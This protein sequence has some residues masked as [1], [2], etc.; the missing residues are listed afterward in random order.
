MEIDPAV[1]AEH[2]Y[3]HSGY[4]SEL[5]AARDL[6]S[7]RNQ[8]D[9]DF[10]P[11]QIS[12]EYR[13]A[14]LLLKALKTSGAPDF[15]LKCEDT[16]YGLQKVIYNNVCMLDLAATGGS[17]SRFR[18]VHEMTEKRA[19]RIYR[20]FLRGANS[21]SYREA[22]RQILEDEKGHLHNYHTDDVVMGHF[23][24][25]DKWAFCDYL[26]RKYGINLLDPS[27]RFWQAYYRQN[28]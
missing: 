26:P 12:D 27:N 11:A 21:A 8:F 23:T 3:M 5:W 9:L 6:E 17:V 15:L 18:A 16:Q 14:E 2:Y 1:N 25:L 7:K 20:T 22:A 10:L 4:V 28:L 13:H 19:L 24:A